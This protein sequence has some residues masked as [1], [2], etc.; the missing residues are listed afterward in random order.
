MGAIARSGD[1]D[2]VGL[3]RGT[4]DGGEKMETLSERAGKENE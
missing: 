1:L 2:A 4:R 3:Y